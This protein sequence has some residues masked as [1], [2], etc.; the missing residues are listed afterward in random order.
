MELRA[1]GDWLLEKDAQ[2]Q[3]ALRYYLGPAYE[4]INALAQF[5]ALMSPGADMMDMAQSSD[6]LMHSP[7]WKDAGLN[8]L[9][10]GAAT[11]G[12]FIPGT[13]RGI[14]EAVDTAADAT[15]KG[16]RAYH[17]SP[18]DFDK[19]SL[20]HIGKGEGAQAYGHGLYFAENEGVAR[21][22]RDALSRDRL[23]TDS[24]DVFNVATIGGWDD[25]ESRYLEPLA[26]AAPPMPRNS[27]SF[28]NNSYEYLI[29]QAYENAE[30]GKDFAEEM[31]NAATW[32]RDMSE[33]EVDR[34]RGYPMEPGT[35][36]VLRKHYLQAADLAESIA[37]GGPQS[38]PGRMY[39]VN[40]KANPDDF[41]D[42][43]K[44]LSEQSAILEKA[45]KA[46]SKYLREIAADPALREASRDVYGTDIG[47]ATGQELVSR[48]GIAL[49]GR[50]GGQSRKAGDA[51]RKAGIPGIKYLDQGSRTAGEGS[52]NYVV[53]DDSM[54]EIL[55]KYGLLGMIGGGAAATA[56]SQ[57][58]GDGA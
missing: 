41:L 44:P 16:I 46:R 15:R 5:G 17:G 7:T 26:E 25:F 4:P 13:A 50:A 49:E 30:P 57:N 19:F 47:P 33:S 40:I 28:T 52:R 20:E 37:S 54:I 38:V 35:L 8:A 23:M 29:G 32:L 58:Y 12:A 53:F 34:L 3:N 27:D 6:A 9:G 1:I 43:D 36:D 10:L 2:A 48:L 31:R 56:A 42:W 39:E 11:L 45:A 14:T 18:H 55:R 24:G 22:Y 51:L 21:S